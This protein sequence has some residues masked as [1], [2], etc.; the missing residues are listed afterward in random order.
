LYTKRNSF[1]WKKAKK[2]W[3]EKTDQWL[4]NEARSFYH[5]EKAGN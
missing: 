1:E 2:K 3:A 5:Q 4:D